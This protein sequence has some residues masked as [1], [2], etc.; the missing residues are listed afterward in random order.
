[1]L[2][3][4]L[5]NK[6]IVADKRTIHV[7]FDKLKPENILKE[8]YRY[9]Q[10]LFSFDPEKEKGGYY[11]ELYLLPL[12]KLLAPY[13][14]V[15]YCSMESVANG[16]Y[17]I[18]ISKLMNVRGVNITED[19]RVQIDYGDV[20]NFQKLTSE[21]LKNYDV[22]VLTKNNAIGWDGGN[23]AFALA[24]L[25]AETGVLDIEHGGRFV[26]DS[27]MLAN[28]NQSICQKGHAIAGVTC[29]G[30]RYMYNGW[31][32]HTNDPAKYYQGRT[33]PCDLIPFDWLTED[34][35][36]CINPRCGLLSA[37]SPDMNQQMCFN[38]HRKA[39]YLALRGG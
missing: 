1:M 20:S 23:P 3:D 32:A 8:L 39:V 7:E 35:H 22:L 24:Q 37:K 29:G 33:N 10:Q 11:S 34:G 36:F 25:D 38:V 19:K 17:Q 31:S 5:H 28:F 13:Q 12:L 16:Q 6:F 21:H 26:I 4:L 27:L 15:L 18:R 9:D 14:R 30:R 2:N